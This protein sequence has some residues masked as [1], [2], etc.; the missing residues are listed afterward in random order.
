MCGG[1]A[2]ATYNEIEGEY[3]YTVSPAMDYFTDKAFTRL[4]VENSV[5]ILSA[6]VK[7]MAEQ[8]LI[9]KHFS[10]LADLGRF[11][12][13]K[14]SITQIMGHLECWIIR[15]KNERSLISALT[16]WRPKAFV[17]FMGIGNQRQFK[18]RLRFG[19]DMQVG[20]V[21]M[22][23]I[24]VRTHT[25]T[26]EVSEPYFSVRVSL[27]GIAAAHGG[28]GKGRGGA[29]ASWG[30]MGILGGSEFDDPDKFHGIGVGINESLVM[31]TGVVSKQGA[32]GF[33]SDIPGVVDLFYVT[34]GGQQGM[35]V[36]AG[37][38]LSGYGFF[39]LGTF[40]EALAGAAVLSNATIQEEV[41]K[42]LSKRLSEMFNRELQGSQVVVDDDADTAAGAETTADHSPGSSDKLSKAERERQESLLCEG[43]EGEFLGVGG[44]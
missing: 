32:I 33:N 39:P 17:V 24:V 43:L 8:G 16:S 31:K 42:Q 35:A 26:G 28:V 11:V 1:K 37:I 6:Q 12:E 20:L 38:D 40:Y 13:F 15:E 19:G 44:S 23:V 2:Q 18:T 34:F 5:N 36:G 4:L 27:V 22:P 10:S 7:E 21:V 9:P 3:I 25:L 14:K 29:H 41:D 30:V